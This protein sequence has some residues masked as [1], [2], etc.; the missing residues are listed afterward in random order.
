MSEM[1]DRNL[2]EE[3][4]AVKGELAALRA[5]RMGPRLGRAIR[6]PKLRLALLCAA[7]VIPTAAYA[8]I[9][10]V[11]NTFSNGTIAD[12]NEVNVN[13]NAIVSESNDQ[14]GRLVALESQ[15]ATLTSGQAAL[16]TSV[17]TNTTDIATNVTNVGTLV[18]SVDDVFSGLL[19]LDSL[20]T[21][22]NSAIVT[23]I[24]SIGGLETTFAG[25]SLV[26]STLT[27]SGINLA[28]VDGSGDTG[29]A[30]NGLGNL[31]I[32]YNENT[33]AATRNGSH[34]Q[35]VGMDHE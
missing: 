22:N 23:N 28:V 2:R 25:A 15:I 33:V 10:G 7:I 9:I 1:D 13:F 6:D 35:V 11:P 14:D 20:I 8:A 3:L 18:T 19:E 21:A 12:A 17:G 32:G 26:G 31:I 24:A 34:N 27:F 30:E 4:E 29:G 5:S 16:T